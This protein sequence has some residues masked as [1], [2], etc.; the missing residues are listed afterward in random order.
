MTDVLAAEE[1]VTVSAVK[2]LLSYLTVE[3]LV[4]EDDD[5]SLTKEIK[6]RIKDDLETRY[7]NSDFN[8]L[9]QLC[10]FV[11]PRFKLNNVSDRAEG[12]EEVEDK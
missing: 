5:T 9:L 1:C 8:F 7:E 12:M 2:P 10:S 4:P 11:D 3:M 6:R